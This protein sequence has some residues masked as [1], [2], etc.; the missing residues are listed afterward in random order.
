M[1][2]VFVLCFYRPCLNCVG[3]V[4]FNRGAVGTV[5]QLYLFQ[6]QYLSRSI[7][8][9]IGSFKKVARLF[10]FSSALASFFQIYL[11]FFDVVVCC[12]QKQKYQVQVAYYITAVSISSGT[13]IYLYILVS[14][15]TFTSTVHCILKIKIFG[16]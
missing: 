16:S 5:F 15:C 8:L 14:T 7:I 6:F 3:V 13:C 2:V 11:K 1:V 12:L 9:V 4:R 10:A